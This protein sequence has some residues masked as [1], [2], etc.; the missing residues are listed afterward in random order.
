MIAGDD[1]LSRALR[2]SPLLLLR[3]TIVV[4]SSP[5]LQYRLVTSLKS[6]ACVSGGLSLVLRHARLRRERGLSET[7]RESHTLIE[8]MMLYY[9][10]AQYPTNHRSRRTYRARVLYCVYSTDY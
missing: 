5:R 10:T 4:T 3:S 7:V 1:A 2:L 6:V 9:V 8:T